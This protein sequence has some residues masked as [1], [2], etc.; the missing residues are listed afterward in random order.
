[1]IKYNLNLTRDYCSHWTL[2]HA[3]RELIANTID[4]Q[5]EIIY[6]A[7]QEPPVLTLVTH[8]VLPIEAFLMGYSVKTGTSSIGQYGEGLKIAL[9]LLLRDNVPFTI[10]AGEYEFKFSFERPDGFGVDTLHVSRAESMDSPE[11]ALKGKTIITLESI[12]SEQLKSVYIVHPE[13]TLIPNSKGFYCQGLLVEKNFYLKTA[14]ITY[15]VNISHSISMNRDRTYFADKEVIVPILEKTL[16]PAF[17]ASDDFSTSMPAH[18]IYRDFSPEYG[19][20]V[21]KARVM[22]KQGL[23]AESLEGTTILFPNTYGYD[24][25]KK[26]GYFVAQYWYEGQELMNAEM[27]DLVNRLRINFDEPID[28]DNDYISTEKVSRSIIRL[29]QILGELAT[30]ELAIFP[31]VDVLLSHIALNDSQRAEIVQYLEDRFLDEEEDNR[32]IEEDN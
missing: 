6:D 14:N 16:D 10:F 27:K 31:I 24:Y 26:K 25:A 2:D 9:L 20:R 18:T 19:Q 29:E 23:D 12:T 13:D 15:G 17:F 30:T 28:I 32:F 22:A 1:M 8:S 5:G 21:A 3:L 11:E 4:E 7:E